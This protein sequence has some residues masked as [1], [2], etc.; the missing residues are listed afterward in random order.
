MATLLRSVFI[1]GSLLLL[2][3]VTALPIDATT[4]TVTG[5]G[6]IAVMVVLGLFAE[7]GIARGVFFACAGF[8]VLRYLYWRIAFTLPSPADYMDFVPSL[9]LLVAELYC[10]GMLTISFFVNARPLHREPPP[11]LRDEEA[12]TVDVFV[13]SYN[14]SPEIVAVTL[15]A[16]K[17]MDHPRDR[18]RVHLLDDGATTEKLQS[19]DPR[20]AAQA[21]ARRQT[22]QR[23]CEELGVVY[24]SRERNVHAKAGNLNHGLANSDGDLVV[25]FDADHVPAREFLRNTIGYFS[26]NERLFLVQTPHHFI[27]P[28]P[29]EKNLATFGRMPSENEMFYSGIQ[30]GLDQWNAAFFCGSAAVLRRSALVEVGGFSGVSITED[31]E[32]AL[33]LHRR[34][35]D[36]IYVDKPMIS[37]LQPE[38]FTSF[39]GQRSRWCRGMLQILLLHNPVFAPGLTLAQRV[40]YLSSNVFW[41]FPLSRLI[42]M[43]SPLLFIF[44]DLKIY[45]SSSREFVA[46]TLTYIVAVLLV[47]NTMFGRVRWPW[48]SELYEYVQSPHLARAILSVLLDPRAPKFDVTAKGQRLER[49]HVSELAKPFYAIFG[50]LAVAFVYSVYRWIEEPQLRDLIAVVGLWNVFNLGLA[51]IG[52]GVVSE[53]RERRG[54]RRMSTGAG[55]AAKIE[56]DLGDRRAEVLVED[57]SIGGLRVRVLGPEIRS[58]ALGVGATVRLSQ[59]GH[60]VDVPVMVQ[61]VR[62]EDDPIIGLAFRD[63]SAA[64]FEVIAALAY[65]DIGDLIDARS[66]RQGGRSLFGG[67]LEIAVWFFRQSSRGLYFLLFRRN[68]PASPRARAVATS[69]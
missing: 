14:E 16:A 67:T 55:T 54:V 41:L 58:S 39:I 2:L 42:F 1:V 68:V 62:I 47:Q 29:V 48:V 52:L 50:V 6:V 43:F 46:Y 25:V 44:F 40:C 35:W 66:A 27:N 34:G 3:L 59:D 31:C 32:T 7:R 19:R 8:V 61:N 20:V 33:Q 60:A 51:G 15:A 36:S 5:V 13:P 37:G 26:E 57:V 17:A 45:N 9:I 23:L 18:L 21:A 22:M 53:R 63:L 4:Q 38:T 49:D 11:V 24:L 12:P 65:A 69:A 30:R 64:R 28:D 56:L 10:I